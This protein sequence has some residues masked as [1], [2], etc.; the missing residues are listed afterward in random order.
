MSLPGPSSSAVTD[1][2]A[3]DPT[4]PRRT[5][6]TPFHSFRLWLHRGPL[7]ERLAAGIAAALAVVLMAWLAVPVQDPDSTMATGPGASAVGNRTGALDPVTDGTAPAAG[8]GESAEATPASGVPDA[9]V[10]GAGSGGGVPAGDSVPS[11][12]DASATTDPCSVP[13]TATD[14]G[15]TESTIH[16]A[17]TTVDLAGP[18]GNAT[19]GVP[20][21]LQEATDAIVSG[22]NAGGGVAC[23]QLQVTQYKVN[24]IDANAQRATCLEIANAGTFAVVD[25]AGFVSASGQACF[26]EH[27]IPYQSGT[28]MTEAQIRSGY[29]F[30]YSALASTDAQLVNLGLG[31]GDRGLLASDEFTK[32]GVFISGCNPELNDRFR[33]DLR[34]IGLDDAHVSWFATSC[35]LVTPPSEVSQ[36][37]G[38]HRRDGVSHVVFGSSIS[39]SQNYVRTASGIGFRPRYIAGDFGSNT[40]GASGWHADFDGALAITSTRSGELSAGI[41]TPAGDQCR[42]WMRDMTLDSDSELNAA[43]LICDE[44]RLFAAAGDAAGPNLTRVDIVPSLAAVGTFASAA[45]GDASFGPEKF[46]GGD[47]IRV[48]QHRADCDCWIATEPTMSAAP[49]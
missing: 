17:V 3:A 36:A 46:W 26:P 18:V 41:T 30:F 5:D 23:R 25:F 15:V 6:V 33:E 8:P 24:P 20:A 39:G 29:P 40:T 12:G 32:L 14:Q 37:V 13:L 49:R 42:Q 16:I 7:A 38:Q 11:G 31:I 34:R 47:F 48:I 22:I 10:S 28:S 35:Q 45:T 1:D 9:P 4:P 44:L 21:S 2:L 43:L 27:Q 19:F